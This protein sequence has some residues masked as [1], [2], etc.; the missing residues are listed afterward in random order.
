MAITTTIQR[1]IRWRSEFN[2]QKMFYSVNF[3][4]FITGANRTQNE[5]KKLHFH[6][7]LTQYGR[8]VSQSFF[9]TKNRKRSQLKSS[10]EKS[11][12]GHTLRFPHSS[13]LNYTF[14][15]LK[16]YLL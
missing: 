4:E 14:K 16:L 1:N 2:S 12:D 13:S 9:H 10:Y 11:P 15:F 5:I 6:E 8:T 7:P 3:L